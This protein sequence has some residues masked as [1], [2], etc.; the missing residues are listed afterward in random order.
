[1]MAVN[2][3]IYNTDDGEHTLI[4]LTED[5]V[6]ADTLAEGA[7]AHSASGETIVGTMPLLELPVPVAKGGTEATTRLEAANNLGVPAMWERTKIPNGTDLN[8]ITTPGSY[9]SQ[10]YLSSTNLVNCPTE[11]PF[12]MNVYYACGDKWYIAQEIIE[13]M[14]G[15]RYFRMITSG[16][17]CYTWVKNYS[18]ASK[19]AIGDCSGH[20][21][22]SQGGTGRTYLTKDC[23][24]VGNNEYGVQ[25]KT[26]A[27]VLADIGAVSLDTYNALLARVEELESTVNDICNQLGIA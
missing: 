3:V 18:N 12:I 20:A 10:S 13:F 14:D 21:I 2:K 19:M 22:V 4:D 11:K 27:E 16:G 17:T 26:K 24:L 7:T 1:M 8:T 23:Y 9:C 6:T 5:T 25:L 15:I